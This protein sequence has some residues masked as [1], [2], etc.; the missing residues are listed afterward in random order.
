MSLQ[1]VAALCEAILRNEHR[2]LPLSVPVKGLHGILHDV[3]LSLPAVVSVTRGSSCCRISPGGHNP[4]LNR[5]SHLRLPLLRFHCL[6]SLPPSPSASSSSSAFLL[7]LGAEGV[8]EVLNVKLD[9][10]ELGKLRASAATIAAVQGELDLEGD[11]AA[12]AAAAAASAAAA[13]GAGAGK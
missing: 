3:Y 7:Q 6:P 11:A 4:S 1:T 8:S 9:E 10:E 2:V 12:A 5:C 13:G